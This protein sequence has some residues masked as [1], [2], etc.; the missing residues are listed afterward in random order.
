VR[1]KIVAALILSCMLCL[2]TPA[3]ADLE[4]QFHDFAALAEACAKRQLEMEVRIRD[5]KKQ[6]DDAFELTEKLGDSYWKLSKDYRMLQ[7]DVK[8]T[9]F[10]GFVLELSSFA[11]SLATGP[12]THSLTNMGLTVAQTELFAISQTM[13]ELV[14]ELSKTAIGHP[15]AETEVKTLLAELEENL[16]RLDTVRK[17]IHNR[18]VKMLKEIKAL[19]AERKKLK[20]RCAEDAAQFDQAVDA[21]QLDQIVL[22]APTT[23]SSNQNRPAVEGYWQLVSISGG[24][25]PPS[26]SHPC[27]HD[28]CKG[29]EGA[30][31]LT[32]LNKCTT[33]KTKFEGV[34]TWSRPPD[35]LRPHQTYSQELT[36]HRLAFDPGLFQDIHLSA[37]IEPS[38]MSC[39]ATAGGK[40]YH[41]Y[42]KVGSK[43]SKGGDRKT[44]KFKAP[45]L[46][47]ADSL[48]TRELALLFCSNAG[49]YKY[50]YRWVPK[51]AKPESVT[52]PPFPG[53]AGH[54]SAQPASSETAKID[55]LSGEWSDPGTQ[56]TWRFTPLQDGTYK[57][58]FRGGIHA[59][60]R[61]RLQGQSLVIELKTGSD[62]VR[63]DLTLSA[64][65]FQAKGSWRA[66]DGEN[67]E[68]ILTRKR[69]PSSIPEQTSSRDKVRPGE[70][71]RRLFD[72]GN[73]QS[74]QN[75]PTAQTIVTISSPQLI[76]R[77]TTYHFNHGKG[78]NTAGSLALKDEKGRIYCPWKK[79]AKNP[80]GTSPL[81]Y[82]TVTPMVVVPAGKYQVVDSNPATWS[83]NSISKGMGITWVEGVPR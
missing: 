36:V 53:K 83:H 19:E 48:A 32:I 5:L 17:Q 14:Q 69:A 80:D 52:L 72:N 62:E 18:R 1:K 49:G 46:G 50:L 47:Y 67:Q 65:G 29:G 43:S 20:Q 35:A 45:G 59:K 3:W 11:Y 79:L 78:D 70:R 74:V 27:Y 12:L 54:L 4:Q 37:N 76:T 64:D 57:A 51:G 26:T 42:L 44:F 25:K 9:E 41:I 16:E 66:S 24:P 68:A 28:L 39:G 38:R 56:G 63:Y 6:A 30:L 77:I 58:E 7:I 60:G 61:A 8:K 2:S 15:Q 55:P 73:P 23:A 31:T 40:E 34:A 82:W 21:A 22:G 75:T 10:L 33:N 13:E 71:V 81:R